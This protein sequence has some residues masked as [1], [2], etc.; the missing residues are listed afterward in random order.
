MRAV[1]EAGRGVM[2]HMMVLAHVVSLALSLSIQ[3]SS[4]VRLCIARTPLIA[5]AAG[6]CPTNW[7]ESTGVE[8]APLAGSG[9]FTY[10]VQQQDGPFFWL[11]CQNN[12]G[13]HCQRGQKILVQVTCG[14]GAGA[15]AAD[16]PAAEVFAGLS[17][18][19]TGGS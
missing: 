15:P 5:P 2:L 19:R 7:N 14:G 16:A 9:N 8:L 1:T 13:R 18:R 17:R 10:T 6:A 11:A 12:Q 4:I 3:H